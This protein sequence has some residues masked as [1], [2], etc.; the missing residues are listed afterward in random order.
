MNAILTGLDF[1]SLA[2]QSGR[3]AEF[4]ARTFNA[5]AF[6]DLEARV[7]QDLA[8]LNYPP[9]NWVPTQEGVLDV[10]V[11][12]A[13][14]CGQTAAYGL[15]R[16]GIRN[17]R[18][19]D[20]SAFS[21]EGPWGTFARMEM[22]RSPKQL[23][24]PDLGVPSLTFRAWYTARFGVSAWDRL[25]KVW[26]SDWRD[27]LLWV[28]AQVGVQV[29][30]GV[31]LRQIEP[32]ENQ[33][34][35]LRVSL[36][37][38]AGEEVLVVRKVVL[39]MGREGSGAPHLPTYPS[40]PQLST[41]VGR[42]HHSMDS[43]DF[44][45]LKGK[46]I[47]VLG[48]GASAFDNA[49][50]A[51][52]AGAHVTMFCRRPALPQINKSKWTAFAGFF[53]GFPYLSDSERW[54][55]YAY[56]FDAQVPPPYESVLRCERWDGFSLKLNETWL[57]VIMQHDGVEVHSS[58]GRYTFDALI[59][60]TGFDVNLQERPELC[61]FAPHILT[62]GDRMGDTSWPGSVES[63][64]RSEAGR[65][66]YLTDDF[67]LQGRTAAAPSTLESLFL[68][69]WGAT[70]SQG[71]VAGDIPGLG[72]GSLK[73]AASIAKALFKEDALKLRDKLLDLSEPEL[74]LTSFY[75]PKNSN[76]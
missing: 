42:I 18:V 55:I 27:Y 67:Q 74:R 7:R 54:Q 15:L 13:G 53:K 28:R 64:S 39:A 50:S 1:G 68:F 5:Q 9:A 11:V 71:A 58:L 21:E 6:A 34:P 31:E 46:R 38:A 36:S 19:I 2:S 69:N 12:G 59:F 41:V 75:Q 43:I 61:V 37:S 40:N 48:V 24:G 52:E 72:H 4:A 23:T 10:L 51:L 25:H 3:A 45:A 16:E 32:V 17:I 29:E 63:D 33:A 70:L 26:R 8:C 35:L 57:D 65:F 66:P 56:I 62:W 22:L 20:R 76:Q 49:A 60:G 44:S 73:L 30:N 14:M 47:G